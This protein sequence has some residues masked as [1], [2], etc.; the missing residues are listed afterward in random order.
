MK[1]DSTPGLCFENSKFKFYFYFFLVI[2]KKNLT[3]LKTA[4]AGLQIVL[5]GCPEAAAFRAELRCLKGGAPLTMSYGLLPGRSLAK[6]CAL[7]SEVPLFLE[8][9]VGPAV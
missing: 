5:L 1:T 2:F 7:G 6:F 4:A 9:S 3:C 8:L